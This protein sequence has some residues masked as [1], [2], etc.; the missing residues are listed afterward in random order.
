M[1]KCDQARSRD[2]DGLSGWGLLGFGRC[3]HPFG[4]FRSVSGTLLYSQA[5]HGCEEELAARG[6]DLGG[7]FLDAVL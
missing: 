5:T 1:G 2:R 3:P 6:I 7:K 4:A